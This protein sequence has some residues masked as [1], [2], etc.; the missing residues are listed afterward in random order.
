MKSLLKSML[1]G[2]GYEL[3]RREAPPSAGGLQRPV[4]DFGCLLEDLRARGFAPRA[5][6][7]G[8]ANSGGWSRL[9]KSIFP[10]A[11]CYL[12]EPQEEMRVSLEEFCRDFPD[13]KYF[14]AGVGAVPGELELN[15]YDDLV[16]S[17]FVSKP[18]ADPRSP[19]KVRRVPIC[20]VDEMVASGKIPQPEL[21]KLDVQGFELE[22]LRGAA[23]VL[24][25]AELAILE[26]SLFH[27]EPAWPILHEVVAFMAA[28]G[29]VTYDFAG[30]RRRP[31]DGALGQ[32]DICFAREDGEL[33][34]KSTWS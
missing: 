6:L 33:R 10:G 32:T 5:I 11:D 18:T 26:V 8:G 3:R 20:T 16:G 15:V 1:R 29:F 22:V 31:L 7:D 13:S 12:F 28:R 14:L 4:G 19:A 23:Q 27:F 21:I 9:A 17:S 30:Y 34:Q 25:K 2:A 24:P